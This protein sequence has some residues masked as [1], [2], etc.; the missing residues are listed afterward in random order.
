MKRYGQDGGSR[1]VER[2][3]HVCGRLKAKVFMFKLHGWLLLVAL[4]GCAG[5]ATAGTT[6][7]VGQRLPA[8]ERVPLAEIDHTVWNELLAEYVNGAGG[9]DYRR[10]RAATEDLQRLEQYLRELSR[11]KIEAQ[12]SRAA[13]LAFWINAYNALTVR[14][15]LAEYPTQSIRDHTPTLFGYNIWNDLRLWVGD[16]AWSL[17][18]IEHGMLRKLGDPR[19]HFAIVC[20]SKGCPRLMN[21]AYAPPEIDEQLTDNARHFFSRPENVHADAGGKRLGLS[22]IMDYFARD[23]GEDQQETLRSIADFLPDGE[24]RSL[25]ESAD[26]QV[27]V[28]PYDWGLNDASTPAE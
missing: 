23:F 7:T 22:F 17:S 16:R 3:S 28:L 2:E 15:I 20:A 4:A 8:T 18:E 21:R 26:V 11:G 12:E 13:Q 1:V 14:G 9:V 6:V 5:E 27:E 10:W 25:T 19:I 24:A